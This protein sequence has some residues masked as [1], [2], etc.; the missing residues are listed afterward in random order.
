ME[1]EQ[2]TNRNQEFTQWTL[3][4]TKGRKKKKFSENS[5]KNPLVL[6]C[7]KKKNQDILQEYPGTNIFRCKKLPL[8]LIITGAS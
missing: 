8:Q 1:L 6:Q 2:W 3:E 4:K 7:K 5:N